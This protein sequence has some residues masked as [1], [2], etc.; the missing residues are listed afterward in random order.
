MRLTNEIIKKFKEYLI[1]NDKS[2]YT[3]EKY[4]RDVFKFKDFLSRD[5]ITKEMTGEYKNYLIR[6]GYS[7]RSINSM[8]SSVN[9][10]LEYLGRNDLKVKTIKMQRSV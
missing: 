9:A 1:N 10:L 3:I 2:S 7:V 8:R 6:N 4:I 5:E